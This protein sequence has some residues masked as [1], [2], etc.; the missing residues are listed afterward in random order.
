[1][2][3]I[4]FD[5]LDK[6]FG[7]DNVRSMASEANSLNDKQNQIMSQLKDIGPVMNQAMNLLKS[8]DMDA[9]NNVSNKMTGMI[10][11]LQDLKS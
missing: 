10:T 3:E 1:M 8:V 9:I 4:A 11:K 7:N 5:N 6:I 2:K